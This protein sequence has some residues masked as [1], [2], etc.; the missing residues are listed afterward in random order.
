MYREY[1][2]AEAVARRKAR[3]AFHEREAE[4]REKEDELELQ[5]CVD[6]YQYNVGL[7][8]AIVEEEE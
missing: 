7:E 2:E 8:H 5:V 3:E 4:L 1:K 6:Q